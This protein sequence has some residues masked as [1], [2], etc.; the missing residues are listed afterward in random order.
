MDLSIALP[1]APKRLFSVF[2]FCRCTE[3]RGAASHLARIGQNSALINVIW[4][5]VLSRFGHGLG[6]PTTAGEVGVKV[7]IVPPKPSPFI[8]GGDFNP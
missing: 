8:A 3:V 6:E 1:N 2:D 7:L 5:T 4:G